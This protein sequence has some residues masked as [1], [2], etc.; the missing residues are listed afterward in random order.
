MATINVA[1][2]NRAAR[3]GPPTSRKG[4]PDVRAGD[5]LTCPAR[6]DTGNRVIKATSGT[7]VTNL[8]ASPP[9]QRPARPGHDAVWLADEWTSSRR[10]SPRDLR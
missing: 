6:A 8:V 5:L 7:T 2:L 9:N 3:R 4:L 1:E 10:T